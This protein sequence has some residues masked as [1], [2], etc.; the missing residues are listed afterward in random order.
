[1][2]NQKLKVLWICCGTEDPGYSGVKAMDELLT[3]KN[4]KHV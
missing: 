2:L 3:R 4:V 1:M